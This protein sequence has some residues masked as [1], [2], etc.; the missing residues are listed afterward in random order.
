M[1]I[2]TYIL[3]I[4]YNTVKPKVLPL[5]PDRRS[6]VHVLQRGPDETGSEDGWGVLP[7][8]QVQDTA[9]VCALSK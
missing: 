8:G 9:G 3:T 7:E 2:L 1:F 4:P 5:I 6:A